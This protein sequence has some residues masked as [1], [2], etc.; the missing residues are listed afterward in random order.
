LKQKRITHSWQEIER[1]GNIQKV[2]A[3][4]GKNQI[5]ETSIRRCSEPIESLK[6]IY[7]GI[8]YK[9]HPFVKRKS[10]I[11]NPELK[12]EETLIS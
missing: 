7:D 1:I 5:D 2:V 3:T 11:Y 6:P 10:A 8:R 4:S 9:T 12:K